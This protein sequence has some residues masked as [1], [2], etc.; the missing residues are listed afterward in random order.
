MLAQ[1]Q[2]EEIKDVLKANRK[3]RVKCD[4][5]I[6]DEFAR[7]DRR[8]TSNEFASGFARHSSARRFRCPAEHSF[9]SPN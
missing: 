3:S 5:L 4:N 6:Q 1:E 8:G 9:L 7:H 2:E